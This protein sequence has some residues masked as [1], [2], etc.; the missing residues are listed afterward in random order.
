MEEMRADF[1]GVTSERRRG[2]HRNNRA[3][4][5]ETASRRL[6]YLRFRFLQPIRHAHVAVHGRRGGEMLPGLLALIR[7]AAELAEAEVTGGDEGRAFQAVV[8]VDRPAIGHLA[9]LGV[10]ESGSLQEIV[11]S[12]RGE[13]TW[14]AR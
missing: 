4:V 12:G 8:Q 13:L 7:A 9:P 6:S 3:V 14:V 11:S 1:I 2:V 5:R 10:E